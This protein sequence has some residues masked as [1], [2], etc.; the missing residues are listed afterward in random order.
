MRSQGEAGKPLDLIHKG[1]QARNLSFVACEQKR[2]RLT[3]ASAQSDQCLCCLLSE[4]KITMSDVSQFSIFLFL[5]ILFFGWM[6]GFNMINPL[7]TY[8]RNNINYYKFRTFC[9]KLNISSRNGET[10]VGKSCSSCEIFWLRKC[11]SKLFAKL[12]LSQ[13]YSIFK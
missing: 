8:L 3:C 10:D 12:E 7:A 13:N 1:C 9:E 2:H 4:T 6:G 11:L 5:F